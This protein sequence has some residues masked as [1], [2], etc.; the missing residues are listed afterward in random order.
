MRK[1]FNMNEHRN[2]KLHCNSE[3]KRLYQPITKQEYIRLETELKDYKGIIKI[4]T[5][6]NTVLY[7]YE[8]LEICQKYNKPYEASRLYV[9]V[10]SNDFDKLE[11][12]FE[13]LFPAVSC[14]KNKFRG[15]IAFITDKEKESLIKEKL[16]KFNNLS[17]L[18]VLHTFF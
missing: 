18:K 11:A 14:V 17:S 15:E 12:Q 4:K 13:A 6:A 7:D 8:K 2:P 3:Y 10:A 16:S 9:R 1:K 5:W